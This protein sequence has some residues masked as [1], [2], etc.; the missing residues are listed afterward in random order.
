MVNQMIVCVQPAKGA[1]RLFCSDQPRRPGYSK[2]AQ[3]EPMRAILHEMIGA[4]AKCWEEQHDRRIK[5]LEEKR[6]IG[7]RIIT[8]YIK[9]FGCIRPRST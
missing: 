3:E 5:E 7:E 1:N 2:G 4:A 8:E 9:R 6:R